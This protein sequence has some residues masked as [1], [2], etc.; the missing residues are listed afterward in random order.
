MKNNKAI[1][2]YME[3]MSKDISD[4]Y[5]ALRLAFLREGWSEEDLENPPY[6]PNDIMRN[7][8]KFSGAQNILFSDVRDKFNLS[9]EE[10][11]EYL[12]GVLS[13]IDEKTPLNKK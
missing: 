3:I 8:Q 9:W 5:Y 1:K 6:Y 12:I 13:G 2:K 10:F 4:I 7:Y 11:N